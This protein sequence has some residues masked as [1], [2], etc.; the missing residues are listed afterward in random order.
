MKTSTK[1]IIGVI[2]IICL[3]FIIIPRLDLGEE[4]QQEPVQT[5]GSEPLQVNAV[6]VKNKPLDNNLKVTG[7]LTANESVMLRSEVSGLVEQIL[8]EEGQKVKKGQLLIKLNDDELKAELEKL[9]FTK[10]LNE[11]IE[12]RQ[13]Q[14][15]AK[16]AISKEEYETA[17]TT[18]NT[19]LAEI[20]V[21][22]VQ[23][24]KHQIRAPFDG[25]IGLRQ[26]STGSYINPS[27]EI[28]TLYSINPIKIDLSVPGRYT[29][30]VNNGDKITFTVDA[31]SDTFTGEI[32]AIEPQIDPQTRS[33]KIR[34]VS[35]NKENKLL[36]GQ[37]AKITLTISTFDEALMIPTEAVVPE[38][39]G[40]KVFVMRNGKIANQ[41]I[42]TGIRTA[43]NVQV[44]EGLQN[45]DTV[46]TTGILQVKPGMNVALEIGDVAYE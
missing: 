24:D 26:I 41:Q 12:Y 1:I 9:Q 3:A 40:K 45:G 31:Y 4:K 33:I 13:K 5:Q 32:Y 23:I 43:N 35:Q 21:K 37:F 2:V 30:E 46:I 29:S 16:E 27:D 25:I 28:A 11:D 6:I 38:L 8:F 18:L 17:L 22:Q 15:L 39:D 34:A 44:T 7:S 42:Q 10:K 36:P 14:L 20:K 19:S